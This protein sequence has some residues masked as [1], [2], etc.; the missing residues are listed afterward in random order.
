MVADVLADWDCGGRDTGL[1]RLW[2]LLVDCRDGGGGAPAAA[3]VAGLYDEGGGWAMGMSNSFPEKTVPPCDGV[4]GVCRSSLFCVE[5]AAG[6]VAIKL[7]YYEW[8]RWVV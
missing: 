5:R 3:A 7:G 2:P 1:G 6:Y 4:I 8:T